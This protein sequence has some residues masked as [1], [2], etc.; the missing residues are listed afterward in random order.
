M[1][2]NQPDFYLENSIDVVEGSFLDDQSSVIP[3]EPRGSQ[4]RYDENK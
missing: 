4:D 3:S 2:I 1:I